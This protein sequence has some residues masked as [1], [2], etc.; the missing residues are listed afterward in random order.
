MR[1]KSKKEGWKEGNKSNEEGRRRWK[2][3]GG[4]KEGRKDEEIGVI[5]KEEIYENKE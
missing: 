2:E 1:V 5:R 4:R 3:K